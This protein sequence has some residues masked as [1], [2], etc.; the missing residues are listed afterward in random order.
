MIKKQGGARAAFLLILGSL[1][2]N[3][4]SVVLLQTPQQYNIMWILTD[5]ASVLLI[6]LIFALHW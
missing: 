1:V 2:L 4:S 3:M 5:L 6:S